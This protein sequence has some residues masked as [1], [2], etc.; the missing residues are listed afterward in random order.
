MTKNK[1]SRQT[2]ATNNKYFQKTLI[3]LSI[4]YVYPNSRLEMQQACRTF[5]LGQIAALVNVANR[6]KLYEQPERERQ[7]AAF[8][9][10]VKAFGIY[11][12]DSYKSMGIP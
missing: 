11:M 12:G 10:T 3:A 1:L 5:M 8:A 4:D 6:I 9:E 2:P 7:Q